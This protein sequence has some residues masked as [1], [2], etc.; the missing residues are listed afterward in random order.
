M[1]DSLSPPRAECCRIPAGPSPVH[2]QKGQKL[3]R[4]C[5]PDKTTQGPRKAHQSF[6]APFLA[7]TKAWASLAE[8]APTFGVPYDHLVTLSKPFLPLLTPLPWG[9]LGVRKWMLKLLMPPKKD[10]SPR[11]RAKIADMTLLRKP[12]HYPASACHGLKAN[13]EF[14]INLIST[15]SS[16][17]HPSTSKE[18]REIYAFSSLQAGGPPHETDMLVMSLTLAIALLFE[19]MS[20]KSRPT[21]SPL[22]TGTCG[23]PKTLKA[24][25]FDNSFSGNCHSRSI[26]ADL[27]L[28]FQEPTYATGAAV[29]G[30]VNNRRNPVYPYSCFNAPIRRAAP[31]R[32]ALPARVV[33]VTVAPPIVLITWISFFPTA[34]CGSHALRYQF[35]LQEQSTTNKTNYF[36][37]TADFSMYYLPAVRAYRCTLVRVYKGLSTLAPPCEG[38]EGLLGP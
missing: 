2:H 22:S 21:V 3:P 14:C 27:A 37:L 32:H 36:T 38:Y 5:D 34:G 23:G 24:V 10:S 16:G 28:I 13:S 25:C 20:R 4:P 1:S 7:V 8:G 12:L 11:S 6:D 30:S 35:A 29:P 9:H 17:K 33:T 15:Q 26:I 18:N 19:L 31:P